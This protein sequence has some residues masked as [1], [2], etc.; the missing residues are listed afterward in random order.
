MRREYANT[1]INQYIERIYSYV[2]QRISNEADI[3]DIAQ[4]ICFH[5]YKAALTKEIYAL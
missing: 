4:D 1:I 3:C 2:S 5:I